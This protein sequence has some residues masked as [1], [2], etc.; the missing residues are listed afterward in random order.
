MQN[1]WRSTAVAAAAAA[2]GARA[3]YAALSAN[4]GVALPRFR[5]RPSLVCVRS[6][7]VLLAGARTQRQISTYL[8]YRSFSTDERNTRRFEWW[9]EARGRRDTEVETPQD[10]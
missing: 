1:H 2:A 4:T 6:N 7:G 10:R 8:L 3:A 5:A 9:R